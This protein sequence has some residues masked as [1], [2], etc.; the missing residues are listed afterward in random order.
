MTKIKQ[1]R[2]EEDCRVWSIYMK[3]TEQ[4]ALHPLGALNRGGA[5]LANGQPWLSNI[6]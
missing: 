6:S 3:G 5:T 1:A 2:E 4:K